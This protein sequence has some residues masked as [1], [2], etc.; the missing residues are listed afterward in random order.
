ML[1]RKARPALAKVEAPVSGTVSISQSCLPDT[2]RICGYSSSGQQHPQGK[3]KCPRGV[4]GH[5]TAWWWTWPRQKRT[6]R[7]R[8]R[9]CSGSGRVG[10]VRRLL[11]VVLAWAHTFK[12]Q[13]QLRQPALDVRPDPCPKRRPPRGK[14]L[15]CWWTDRRCRMGFRPSDR[16]SAVLPEAR[17]SLTGR[18]LPLVR[19]H[20]EG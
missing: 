2:Y 6:E 12:A 17:S 9:W 5:R 13:T 20:G 15:S 14:L 16:V 18:R 11:L 3:T 1:P 8:S 19:R 7:R 4:R 10:G